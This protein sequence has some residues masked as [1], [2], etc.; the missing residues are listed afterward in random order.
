MADHSAIEWTEATW[1]PTIGC[2]KVSPGCDRCYAERVTIRFRKNFPNGF[3]LTLRPE[4]LDLPL[5]WRKPRTIFVNSMSDL[6]HVEVPDS[7]IKKVFDYNDSIDLRQDSVVNDVAD[8][9]RSSPCVLAECTARLVTPNGLC[10]TLLHTP[11]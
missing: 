11:P 6:F 10:D 9:D 5:R 8:V 4:V 7:Y 2:T 3:K 1:N